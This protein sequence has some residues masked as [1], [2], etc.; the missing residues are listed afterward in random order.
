MDSASVAELI[1][2]A[3]HWG[4]INLQVRGSSMYPTIVSGEFVTVAALS[5]Q[6]LHCGDLVVA[7][8]DSGLIVVHR[9]VRSDGILVTKGDAN[10][11]TDLPVKR[12]LGRV[13]AKRATFRSRLRRAYWPV[14][15]F[16]RFACDA[17]KSSA[18]LGTPG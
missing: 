10:R 4:T 13:I 18:R 17:F 9:L 1:Q 11:Q 16:G 12:L 14:L 3:L 15:R 8:L 2:T 6:A 7:E 5:A